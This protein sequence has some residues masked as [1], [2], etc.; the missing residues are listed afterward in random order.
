MRAAKFDESLFKQLAGR[1]GENLISAFVPTHRTSRDINQN[2]IHLKNQLS[3]A[4]QA[5]T[6]RGYKPRNVDSRMTA[7]RELLEDLDFWE[8]QEAGL[9]VFIDD[10]GETTAVS[11]FKRLEPAVHI[12]PVFTLRP[13]LSDITPIRAQV[14]VLTKGAVD[15]FTATGTE[16]APMEIGL[17]SYDDVNWFIDR[18]KARQQHP[19]RAHSDRNRHGHEASGVEED[20]G[21]FLREVDSAIESDSTAPLIVLGDDDLV[22][23]FVNQ[24]ER[25]T[26]SPENSGMTAPFTVH[27]V[28]RKVSRILTELETEWIEAARATALDRLGE[29]R[30]T[31]EIEAALKAALAGRVESVVMVREAP[32]VWGRL[33]EST[34][35][36]EL[37]DAQRPGDV[38][39]LDR[40]MVWARDTGAEVIPS[41]SSLDGSAFIATFRY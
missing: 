12:M 32:P 14:L 26:R 31:A 9:A 40:L 8:H 16:V 19:D 2:R 15:M 30:A 18:E 24:S 36:A 4:E 29:G 6:D 13:L 33:D 39:L 23:A 28:K 21:R 27:E 5:L 22:A 38:D 3:V 41:E 17:P 35:E 10:D 34:Q 7:A 1:S 20:L 25:S 11:S 37:H